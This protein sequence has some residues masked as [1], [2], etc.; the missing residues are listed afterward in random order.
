MAIISSI[1]WETSD[2]LKY[3]LLSKVVLTNLEK[4]LKTK[5]NKKQLGL[6]LSFSNFSF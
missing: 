5:Q 3:V 6:Y 4:Q 1:H 2:Q